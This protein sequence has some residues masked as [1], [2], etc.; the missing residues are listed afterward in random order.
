[1][2]KETM[3][4]LKACV[5][6]P[7]YNNGAT[8]VEVL[9]GI[10]AE[11]ADVIVVVDGST[12]DTRERLQTLSLS[13]DV[14]YFATNQGKG[15]AL[16]AGFRRAAERGFRY[17]V[18]IDSDGQ[19]YP[20]DIPRLVEAVEANPG[21]L[22]VGSRGMRH[23]NMP[24]GNSFANRFSN[25]WF[26]VHTWH[27]LPDT[28]TGFRLYPLRFAAR[29]QWLTSRYEAELELLVLAAWRGIELVPVA[30]RVYYPPAEERVSHFRPVY[31]FARISL[32]NTVLC[33]IAV[34][35]GYPRMIYNKVVKLLK[36]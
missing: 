28:Q 20:A 11:C 3:K 18:T 5:V 19:H 10:A 16:K 32:L 26:A 35:Y 31:D 12:D 7:S 8:L 23:D 9:E 30:V 36:K 14:I 6:V 4:R 1:M 24:G 17:A 2:S 22:V 25:F 29:Q 15:E 21:A 27:R 33:A 34:V 13:L